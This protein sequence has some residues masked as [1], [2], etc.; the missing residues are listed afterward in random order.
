MNRAARVFQLL[1]VCALAGVFL[2]GLAHAQAPS[3]LIINYPE[4]TDVD[5]GLQLG[6]YFTLTDGSGRV[7]PDARVAS[8]RI[9]LDD[10]EVVENATVAQPETPFY[11]ALVLDASGSMGGAAND[12]RQAAIRAIEDAPE[13]ARFAVIRFNE[14]IDTLQMFTEDRNRAI[15]AVGDVQPVNLSGTCLYD[16]S[17]QAVGLMGDAPPGRRAIIVFTDGKDEVLGGDPC[18][19]NT[20]QDVVEAAN[21]PGSRVPIHTIGMSTRAENINA[22]ELR[23]MAQQTGGLSAIGEQ[24]ELGDLFQNIMDGLKSQY[25]ATGLF[26]PLQGQHTATLSVTLEDGTLLT[27]VTTFEVTR[28]YRQATPTPTPVV[29]DL[30]IVSVQSDITQETIYLEVAVRGEQVISEFRFDFFDAQTNQLLDRQVVPRPLPSP[31]AL[32]AEQLEGEIRVEL[33]ALDAQGNFIAWP[34]ERDRLID[35]VEHEFAYVRPTP[36]PPPATLTPIPVAVELNSISYDQDSDIISLDLSLTGAEQM[37]ALEINVLDAETNL[38]VSVYPNIRPAGTVSIRA[39]NLQPG[40]EY[41]V[42]I[43]SES[44]AGETRR[45]ESMSFVY[46]P[47][48]TP[49]P[50]PT[51]TPT[52]TPTEAPLVVSIDGIDI[53]QGTEDLVVKL[54]EI[55]D[56]RIASYQLQLRDSDGLVVGEFV[57]TPPPY[58][59]RVPLARLAP[60]EYTA[61]LRAL[62]PGGALLV[63]A[64]PLSFAYNPPPTPTPTPTATPTPTPTPTPQPGFVEEVTGAVR[65]NPALTG[66]VVVIALALLALLVLLVRPRNKQQTGTDFLSAQTGFYQMPSEGAPPEAGAGPERAAGAAAT[67]LEAAPATNVFEGALVPRAE[68]AIERSPARERIGPRVT[69]AAVPFLIGRSLD[70]PNGLSLDEDTSVSRRHAQITYEDGVFYLA[71]VGSSNGTTVGG[72]R[73]KPH[74]PVPLPDGAP[75]VFGKHTAVTFH[76]SGEAGDDRTFMGDDPDRTNYVDMNADR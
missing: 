3:G 36:T 63:E 8:A 47:F 37:E 43:V 66:V 61:I 65:D 73:L 67:Q 45:S 23:N 64:S 68:L 28:D 4:L 18:S 52:A 15:N 42:Y 62:G 54:R 25:L 59:I 35:K 34:G 69:V 10:G 14:N 40:Q 58:A 16:A 33:R 49:T 17:Y 72:H 13:N 41:V 7:V 21:Q 1:V 5:D 71:D 46:T 38:R 31:V 27:G 57:H 53:D 75:I 20:F 30:E 55:A 44:L 32:P 9:Q 39:Q 70:D 24:G 26:Y 74:V 48:L 50:T 6:L 2:P 22:S 11:I 56:E 29:V 51:A 19:R 12:M 76:I 60:G